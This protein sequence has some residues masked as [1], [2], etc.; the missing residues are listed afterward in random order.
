MSTVSRK[1]GAYYGTSGRY[2]NITIN[3]E[4]IFNQEIRYANVIRDNLIVTLFLLGFL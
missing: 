2:L 3:E 4:W 1:R